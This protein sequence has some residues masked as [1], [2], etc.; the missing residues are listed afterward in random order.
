MTNAQR[1]LVLTLGMLL[2][3]VLFL[4]GLLENSLLILFGG[5]IVSIG[6]GF[7]FWMGRSKEPHSGGR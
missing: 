7:Y 5:P 2:A 3:P 1:K 4:Y 6:F